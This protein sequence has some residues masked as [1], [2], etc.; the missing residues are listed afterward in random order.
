MGLLTLSKVC[1]ACSCEGKTWKH[2]SPIGIKCWPILPRLLMKVFLK[3]CFTNRSRIARP[4]NMIWMSII[5]PMKEPVRKPTS[6]LFQP[7]DA[8]LT[9]RG[10]KRIEI[11]LPKAF[12]VPVA[13][14]LEQSRAR[15]ASFQRGTVWPGIRE[16][17]V[18]TT[19]HTSMKPQSHKTRVVSRVMWAS[20]YCEAPP[21][22]NLRI[23]YNSHFFLPPPQHF[24]GQSTQERISIYFQLISIYFQFTFNL[25]LIYFQFTFNWFQ[26]TVNLLSIDFNLLSI[27]FNL[28]LI[29]FQLTFNW[30]QFT[31]NL[32]LFFFHSQKLV[33][34]IEYHPNNYIIE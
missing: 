33:L 21:L 4:F 5:E 17:V 25:L 6:F 28:L 32:L 18:R 15:Q 30:F 2:S 8:T 11:G 24:F 31:F 7:S 3:P 22:N 13:P 34:T 26:F 1:S 12:Q 14:L 27:D 10:L 29:Y 16:A 23:L 20:D 19:A 9:V